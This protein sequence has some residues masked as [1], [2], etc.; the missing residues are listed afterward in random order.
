MTTRKYSSRSQ[1]TTLTSAVTSGAVVLPVVS[2][3][4]LLGGATVSTG[5]TFTVVI[6]PDTALEEIV[7]VTVI[8]GN[9]LTVTRAVDMAGAAAQDHSSGA[10][11]RHM[12]IGRDLRESNTHIEASTAY[13]D[14][15]GTHA[16]HGLG[17][18]DGSVVGTDA[19]Q[20]LTNKTLIAP[21]LT[22]LFENDA[23]ITFEGAT[24]DAFETTLTVVDPTQ[25]NT[26][27]LP[28]T[29]GTVVLATATQTL[30]NKTLTSPTISGSPV[31]TG[32]S[33][34]GMS[35]SS[36][37]PKDYVD[38]IL[39][40]AVAASTSAASA[41]VSAT[42][43]AT[44]A[45][46]ALTS[47]NSAAASA[48][49]SA[50]SAATATTQ[51]TAATTSATS[52]A[53]SATAAATSAASAATSASAAA[54]SATS[55]AASATTAAASVASIATYASNALASQNAASTSATSAA[56]S[57]TAA[58][59]SATSAAASASS[60]TASV[61]A[62]AT[63]AT[64]AAA[65]ATAAATS[66]TSAAASASAAATSATSAAASQTA[67]ATSASSALTSQTAA[68]TSASSALT[69]QTAAATSAAS[70]ATSA[71]S[72]ATSAS[73]SAT[74][75]TA[76]DQRYLG[77]KSSAPTVDNLGNALIIG[78]TYW[79][80]SLN[81]M[82]VWSGSV[83]VQI[84]TTSVYT[85]P[86]LGST[87][88]ASGTTYST[89]G[90]LTLSGGLAT[91][92]PTTDLGLATKQYVDAV[93]AAI[94]FHA[95][96]KLATTSNLSVTYSN[97]TSGV[98]ATLT[99]TGNGR[100]SI[101]GVNITTGD[102]ILVK[103]QT[104]DLQN[105][106]YTVTNQ[107]AGGAPYV[108]TRA[109]DYDNSVEVANGDVIFCTAGTA[110]TGVTFVNTSTNPVTIGT[111][112][113]TFSVYTSASL[114][115]Q[116][117][118]SGKYLTTDGTTPSWGTVASYTAPTLGSTSIGSGATVTTINGLTKIVSATVAKLDASGYEQ[119]FDL[120]TIMGAI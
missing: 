107:G 90:S 86:T 61:A 20:T 43:S 30:T 116:T 105:G 22:G 32:L 46:A 109:T 15:T 45:S 92:D 18:S 49:A 28:N 65:S 96:V 54:T 16:L 9:N 106:I 64:S 113:I 48:T 4:T 12:I 69:S 104:T 71:T 78:A 58:A 76:Y 81:N 91:A 6:D 108:L 68:A 117:G 98:G 72:S 34:A 19:T 36:A 3:T 38:S 11:I 120:L 13:N 35:A 88:I 102:R 5:Q 39:G 100:G 57:A 14:G 2:A 119:D 26:I 63:S 51:A 83:W 33:S 115:S 37:A 59:T 66:A 95:P 77:S 73:S 82:Y 70:A 24:A 60:M 80:T 42:S 17:S 62:A 25:D 112:A 8:S 44:S 97:G 75:Y 89:I 114:P 67:A 7:E 110:N 47:A 40:S 103:N 84:A 87:T 31:I 53:A 79:S 85:A 1:Q 23:S 118:Q 52:A 55:A 41:A 93:T 29:T 50:A 99:A 27:T 94:N 21:T 101:D 56:A 111:T 10:V 74:T